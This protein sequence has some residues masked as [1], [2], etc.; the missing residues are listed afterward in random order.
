MTLV[1]TLIAVLFLGFAVLFH[2]INKERRNRDGDIQ[3]VIN[4]FAQSDTSLM[5]TIEKDMTRFRDLTHTVENK[6]NE[7][8][9]KLRAELIDIRD[10]GVTLE[11]VL[12]E[13]IVFSDK[14]LTGVKEELGIL[15]VDVFMLQN[16]FTNAKFE[17]N[18]DEKEV[19]S[20]HLAGNEI[21][22]KMWDGKKNKLPIR[23]FYENWLNGTYIE[24]K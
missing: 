16:H 18:N 14:N 10:L 7:R 22:I 3:N 4:L 5:E 13:S 20:A 21:M 9:A 15:A 24:V 17:L 11:S 23:E 6:I 19:F 8:I 12:K 1:Y 2:L